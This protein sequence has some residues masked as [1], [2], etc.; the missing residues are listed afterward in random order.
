MQCKWVI[1][2]KN[3][4]E[5]HQ[6]KQREMLMICP[7]SPSELHMKQLDD[8]NTGPVPQWKE[9][10]SRSFGPEVCFVSAT[11]GHFWNS[12]DML[13]QKWCLI[14][15]HLQFL[16]LKPMCT[17][18]LW[19]VHNSILGRH[20]GQKKTGEKAIQSFYW[21][22]IYEDCK[23]WVA[24]CDEC[25]QVKYSPQKPSPLGEIAS[26]CTIWPNFLHIS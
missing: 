17:N 12:W 8:S 10:C 24:K 18:V 7:Y 9:P 4:V 21:S 26:W 1:L 11:T 19:H 6:R 14:N 3:L 15:N 5:G 16:L 20:L 2:N 23:N 25:D 22:E 13:H